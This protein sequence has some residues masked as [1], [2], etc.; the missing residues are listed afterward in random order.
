MTILLLCLVPGI[1]SAIHDPST[2]AMHR[3]AMQWRR[4]Y[5]LAE[6]SL[7]EDCCRLAQQHAKYMARHEYYE[8][9]A[10]DQVITIGYRT[11]AAAVRSWIYSPPHLRWMLSGN[12]KAGWG[13]AVSP[14]GRHYWCGVFR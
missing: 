14:A 12:K 10:N 9:G 5:G 13:H 2:V 3:S 7:D 8:H 11:P 1:P 4:H 6:Q